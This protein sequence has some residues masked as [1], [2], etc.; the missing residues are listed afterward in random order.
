MSRPLNLKVRANGIL[1]SARIGK[2]ANYETG[3]WI[4]VCPKCR[5]S[6]DNVVARVLQ[7]GFWTQKSYVVK[8]CTICDCVF[9][10]V[11]EMDGDNIV[12]LEPEPK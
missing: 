7:Y 8:Q 5:N 2:L 10:G 11:Y 3:G 12:I 1:L 9:Y 6:S 4:V